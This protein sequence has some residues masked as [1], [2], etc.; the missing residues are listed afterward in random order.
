MEEEFGCSAAHRDGK[1]EWEA[2]GAKARVYL[3][4][5]A[6]INVY[7]THLLHPVIPDS[8]FSFNNTRIM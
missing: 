3:A 2:S 8:K 6:D 7:S 4:L 5:T 1:G